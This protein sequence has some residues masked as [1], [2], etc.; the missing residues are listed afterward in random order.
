MKT[1]TLALALTASA[2]FAQ[3]L[4]S[5]HVDVIG[6]YNPTAT[7]G[8]SLTGAYSHL[9]SQSGTYSFSAVDVTFG[10]ATTTTA[11]GV[12]GLVSRVQVATTSGLA[13]RLTSLMGFDVYGI[14]TAGLTTVAG[15]GTT[16]FVA[17]GGFL[18]VHPLKKGWTVDLHA[19]TIAGT[20]SPQYVL[21]LGFG[22][23]K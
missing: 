18:A 16:G 10:S 21:G 9:L 22:F 17:S 23:G 8:G 14:G 5:E 15:G 12:S 20:G 6:T 2:A 11:K 13:Q 4:P 3:S 7:P 1:L 19:R